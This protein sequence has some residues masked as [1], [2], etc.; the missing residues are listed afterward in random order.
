MQSCLFA[1]W[2]VIDAPPS[3]VFHHIHVC[4]I[5][6]LIELTRLTIK[7]DTVRLICA[8]PFQVGVHDAVAFHRRVLKR[9]LA[10]R[11]CTCPAIDRVRMCA[12][13][14]KRLC[15]ISHVL[16]PFLFVFDGNRLPFEVLAATL[17]FIHILLI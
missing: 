5:L 11:K 12:P 8:A 13:D 10:M 1:F 17:P 4:G 7:V 9:R 6:A 3:H 14:M 15:Y 2:L 16:H